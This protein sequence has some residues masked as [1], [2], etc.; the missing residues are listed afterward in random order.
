MPMLQ[1]ERLNG[2]SHLLGTVLA[3]AGTV[4]LLIK[5]GMGGDIR[6]IV[7]TGIYAATLLLLYL[8]STF[9]HSLGEGAARRLFLK[10]DHLAIYLLI[11]GTYTPFTLV[12]L[13]GA[14]GWTLF[15]IVWGLA[16]VGIVLDLFHRKGL[17]WM[18]M[19][20]YLVMGWIVVIAWPQLVEA[21]EPAGIAWL[22]AG[23]VVYTLGTIFYGLDKRMRHAHGIW[24]LFVL[25]GSTCHFIAVFVYVV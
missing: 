4:L 9:Y 21:L 18:Q 8:S 13:R 10:L 20:I 17:R 23:G 14:W 11:A 1:G 2:Y 12:T 3:V 5:A 7:S 16:A 19:I 22:V 6:K 24:H 15:G 25:G